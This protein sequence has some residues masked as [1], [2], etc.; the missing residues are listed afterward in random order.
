MIEQDAP[1]DQPAADLN[2][3][4][5]NQEVGAPQLPQVDKD[6]PLRASATSI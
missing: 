1:N 4:N 5:V 3:Q 2:M 6:S